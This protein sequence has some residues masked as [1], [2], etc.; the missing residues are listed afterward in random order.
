MDYLAKRRRARLWGRPQ[1]QCDLM[2]DIVLARTLHV[3]AVVHWIGGLCF[4][5][6]VLLPGIA[7]V[8]DAARRFVLFELVER[9]FSTQVRVSVPV[10]GLS[11]LYMT[12]K[13]NAWERFLHAQSW[14][15]A[16][17]ALLWLLFMAILFIVEPLAKTRVVQMASRQ[18]AR[19]FALLQRAHW[20]LAGLG[21]GVTAAGVLGA[22]GL[23]S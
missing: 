6:A 2:E 13:L 20:I 18:P 16:A 21:F 9:R 11:G 3:L 19:G 23:L 17:M 5:T 22:H 7:T 14:W 12:W 1:R 4:V 15:L 8:P 10:A